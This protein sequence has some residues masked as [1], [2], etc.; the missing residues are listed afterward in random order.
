MKVLYCCKSELENR[1]L[2]EI[3]KEMDDR[4]APRPQPSLRANATK[5]LQPKS[6]PP[7]ATKQQQRQHTNKSD[8]PGSKYKHIKGTGYG[9]SWSAMSVRPQPHQ[10][11]P[12]Q[13]QHRQRSPQN[14]SYTSTS[15]VGD[16]DARDEIN[17]N[18]VDRLKSIM[19]FPSRLGTKK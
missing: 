18:L 3:L 17:T 6:T 15:F 11:Q 9:T 16:E 19:K 4:A 8:W 12:L 2:E 14:R 5:T 10:Q 13:Q 7:P 1:A